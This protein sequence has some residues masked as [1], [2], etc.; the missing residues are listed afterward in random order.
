[1]SQQSSKRPVLVNLQKQAAGQ[2]LPTSMGSLL[3]K[4]VSTQARHSYLIALLLC[5]AAK[6]WGSRNPP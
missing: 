3:A 6:V 2:Q 1:M 4:K 5:P